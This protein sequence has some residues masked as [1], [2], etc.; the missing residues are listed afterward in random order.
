MTGLTPQQHEALRADIKE[1][2]D[3]LDKLQNIASLLLK[4]NAM[5]PKSAVH[6]T[7][8]EILASENAL[9]EIM[10]ELALIVPAPETQGVI[11]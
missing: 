3:D 5:F 6:M 1:L 8:S 10:T 7:R 4:W 9:D 11:A 2:Q